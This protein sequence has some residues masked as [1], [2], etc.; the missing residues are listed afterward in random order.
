MKESNFGNRIF[1]SFGK[2]INE[3]I[4]GPMEVPFNSPCH[5]LY[6]SIDQ[7]IKHLLDYYG[8]GGIYTC[9][10][11]IILER[12]WITWHF[13]LC[14]HAKIFQRTLVPITWNYFYSSSRDRGKTINVEVEDVNVPLD[15]NLLVERSYNYS[16]MNVV[17]LIW[18]VEFPHEGNISIID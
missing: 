1:R 11:L 6:P 3:I 13:P 17:S 15:Y 2:L 8:Q 10:L 4:F 12:Y 16:I 18:V 14:N 5:I 9:Y 7:K